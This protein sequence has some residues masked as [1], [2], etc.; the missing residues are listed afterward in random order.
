[1]SHRAILDEA[2]Y[3][4][5]ALRLDTSGYPLAPP[6]LASSPRDHS[7]LLDGQPQAKVAQQWLHGGGP[8]SPSMPRWR[9]T[10]PGPCRPG[11]AREEERAR[12]VGQPPDF[13]ALAGRPALQR[14]A[15]AL[16]DE[17][18]RWPRGADR[19]VEAGANYELTRTVAEETIARH[20]VSPDRV[21]GIVLVLDV[22]G[23]W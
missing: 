23:P 9:R 18:R 10:Q 22:G 5:D 4:R 12:T 16:H 11:C 20:G 13:A 21:N 19:Q 8:H 17:A 6:P 2:L 1:V 14:A 15:I 3:V 7:R